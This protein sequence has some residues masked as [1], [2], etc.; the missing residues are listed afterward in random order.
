MSVWVGFYD[1][2]TGEITGVTTGTPRSIIAHR[3]P[4]VILPEYRKDWD[5]THIVV[6]DQLT[7]RPPEALAALYLQ[8]AMVDLRVRRNGLL[9][10]D[11]DPIVTNPLRWD[12]LTDE[13]RVALTAYR[14]ALLDWPETETDPLN[15]TPPVAP[16]F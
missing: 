1:H 16:E 14:Q 15:P 4:F 9:K 11:V 6:N 3:Q 7:P 13:N 2:E 5:L 8:R 10:N 12:G